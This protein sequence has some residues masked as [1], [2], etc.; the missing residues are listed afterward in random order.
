MIKYIF[1]KG[2]SSLAKRHFGRKKISRPEYVSF[3]SP[4]MK[5]MKMM[6]Q[7]AQSR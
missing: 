7:K 3:D 2:L 4:Q 6:V 1:G 5:E